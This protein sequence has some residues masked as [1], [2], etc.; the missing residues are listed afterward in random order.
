MKINAISD[1]HGKIELDKLTIDGEILC[2]AGDFIPLSIQ[3]NIP[4]SLKWIKEKFIPWA[5]KLSVNKVFLVA[6]N[7]D[8]VASSTDF[9]D[10]FIN[11]KIIYLEDE[12]YEY[13][14]DSGYT[15]K[16][17]GT[18]WCTKYGNWNFMLD[19]EN[20]AKKYAQIPNDTDILITHMPPSLGRVGTLY[21][22][23]FK[24]YHESVGSSELANK[25]YSS[26]I[27]LTISGHIHTGSHRLDFV[28]R[29]LSKKYHYFVNVS[30]IDENYEPT[31]SICKIDL[32]KQT[33]SQIYSL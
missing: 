4:E 26:D 10:L 2:I 22:G 30:L 27:K 25:I 12:S 23:Y 21:D 6:G 13:L 32:T 19:S 7:H 33:I 18:P 17:Y 31:Y 3:R 8:F 11:T 24:D 5:N 16:I 29:F 9:K 28:K 20:L 1:L 14:S 15:Y